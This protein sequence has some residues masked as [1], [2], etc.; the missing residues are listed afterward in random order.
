MYVIQ[1][2]HPIIH[3]GGSVGCGPI[4]GPYPGGGF[5]LE[6]MPLIVKSMN[7][8]PAYPTGL[9]L[10]TDHIDILYAVDGHDINGAVGVVFENGGGDAFAFL[11]LCPLTRI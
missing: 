10:S 9:T 8:D 1:V 4:Y 11:H 7:S 2:R 5:A 6:A 3:S